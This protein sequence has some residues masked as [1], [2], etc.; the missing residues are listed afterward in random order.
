M[1]QEKSAEQNQLTK[2]E[3]KG[4]PPY[5][6]VFKQAAPQLFNI[7]FIFFVTLSVF[8]TVHSDIQRNK[9]DDFF[10]P[11]KFFVTITCF[12]TFNAFAMLG[13]LATSWCTWVSVGD[14]WN[15][16]D[17]R[18]RGKNGKLIEFDLC[19]SFSAETKAFGLLRVVARRFHS[20]VPR[21]PLLPEGH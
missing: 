17:E 5:W 16:T 1:L 19:F 8:P 9:A 13:S 6:K 14:E 18:E 7:F 12:L 10:I 4:R 2:K 3:T 20:A 11:E 15:E 21:V